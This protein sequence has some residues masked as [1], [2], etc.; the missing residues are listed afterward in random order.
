MDDCNC[1]DCGGSRQKGPCSYDK[2]N[3]NTEIDDIYIKCDCTDCGGVRQKGKC[4]IEISKITIKK[5]SYF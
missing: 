1:T 5:I 2:I 4:L 3:S